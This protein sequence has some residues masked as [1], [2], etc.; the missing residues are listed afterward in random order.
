MNPFLPT[1]VYSSNCILHNCYSDLTTLSCT[2]SFF[3]SMHKPRS[4]RTLCYACLCIHKS[5]LRLQKSIFPVSFNYHCS[6]FIHYSTLTMLNSLLERSNEP[7]M[8]ISILC[9]HSIS[10]VIHIVSYVHNTS[11]LILSTLPCPLVSC[12]H[13][14]TISSLIYKLRITEYFHGRPIE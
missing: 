12:F 8:L 2:S 6:I 7:F 9:S 11:I 10:F 13:I 4:K 14:T 5:V 1:S 3:P